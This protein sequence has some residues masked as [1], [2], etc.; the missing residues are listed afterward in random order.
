M[1]K[2]TQQSRT[3]PKKILGQDDNIYNDFSL[4]YWQVSRKQIYLSKQYAQ[5]YCLFTL[6]F[7]Y[8]SLNV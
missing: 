6:F 2:I 5:W 7:K 3:Q 8:M 4:K 1:Y